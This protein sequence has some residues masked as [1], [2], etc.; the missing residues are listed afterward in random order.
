MGGGTRPGE[1]SSL[2]VSIAGGSTSF[3]ASAVQQETR[4]CNMSTPKLIAH[5]QT[6]APTKYS[7]G[8]SLFLYGSRLLRIS[9]I[10]IYISSTA[11]SEEA[12]GV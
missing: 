8:V 4:R 1:S 9:F 11:Y 5:D 7:A 2:C 6:G 12:E 10:F 3:F